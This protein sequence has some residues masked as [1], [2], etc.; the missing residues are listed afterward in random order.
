VVDT[1]IDDGRI[2][3]EYSDARGYLERPMGKAESDQRKALNRKPFA[4]GIFLLSGER[5]R[6]SNCTGMIRT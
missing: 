3:A 1:V 4:R 6:P 2:V 5:R